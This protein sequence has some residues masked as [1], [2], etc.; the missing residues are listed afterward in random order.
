M[1][2]LQD[3]SKSLAADTKPT[4]KSRTRTET[5]AALDVHRWG[6]ITIR[7]FATANPNKFKMKCDCPYHRGY[8]ECSRSRTFNSKDEA[9]Q[10][11]YMKT[12]ALA[13]S[14]FEGLP[15]EEARRKHVHECEFRAAQVLADG[16]STPSNYFVLGVAAFLSVPFQVL[17]CNGLQMANAKSCSLR[18]EILKIVSTV[19]LQLPRSVAQVILGLPCVGIQSVGCQS[20]GT[21]SVGPNG[22]GRHVGRPQAV[23]SQCVVGPHDVELRAVG[24]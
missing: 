22:V 7:I 11:R 14:G 5:Q 21:C 19:P 8:P 24:S 13:G 6:P 12:W 15:F 1:G 17:W 4:R 3:K 9:S 20:V 10:I 23:G 2:V 16:H 18:S